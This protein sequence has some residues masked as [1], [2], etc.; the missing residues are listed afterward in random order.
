MASLAACQ[1]AHRG[2]NAG[3]IASAAAGVPIA[4][5]IVDGAPPNIRTALASELASAASGPAR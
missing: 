3:P 1:D 4:V 2:P 5:D